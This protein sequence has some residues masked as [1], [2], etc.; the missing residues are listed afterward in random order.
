MSCFQPV[1]IH[2]PFLSSVVPILPTSLVLTPGYAQIAL[3]FF[4]L[5]HQRRPR[6]CFLALSL[7]SPMTT[8]I[9]YICLLQ[10]EF[11]P[12]CADTVAA[13]SPNKFSV[14]LWAGAQTFSDP[15]WK[16]FMCQS[17][18]TGYPLCRRCAVNLLSQLWLLYLSSWQPCSP[19]S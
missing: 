11:L 7:H 1:F 4:Y 14:E 13:S 18:G 3:W 16:C 6:C 9:F 19:P 12:Q 17:S 5:L 2:C 10:S 8:L 15:C